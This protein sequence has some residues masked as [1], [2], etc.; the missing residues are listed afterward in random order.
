VDPI[1]E[2]LLEAI[3]PE[4][5]YKERAGQYTKFGEWY[6]GNVVQDSQYKNAP[7]CDMFIA[8]A[9]NKAGVRDY[10]GEFAWTP[11]HANWFKEQG[12]WSDTPEPGALVFY[13]WSGSKETRKIDHV[14]IVEKV[15]NGKLHTIEG[16]VDK[17]WLKR[18]IRN[19]SK[20]VGYGLPRKVLEN[21]VQPDAGVD[22]SAVPT[23]QPA[24]AATGDGVR[25]DAGA[26][27]PANASAPFELFGAGGVASATGI[28]ALLLGV[29]LVM[30]RVAGRRRSPVS[31]GR[32]RRRGRHHRITM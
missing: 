6:A 26:V 10:V 22:G 25:W 32:H 21:R 9:A 3:R 13:D 7:W 19:E 28:V 14:G 30:N 8:W 16:N 24:R 27:V 18:K 20:V 17:V 15:K 5:G 11:S 23:V 1:A 29:A 4:L 2:G 31:L 12:A